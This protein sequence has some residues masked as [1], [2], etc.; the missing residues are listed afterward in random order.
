MS[1][2]LAG[3]FFTTE[4]PGEP[5]NCKLKSFDYHVEVS[6]VKSSQSH[7]KGAHTGQR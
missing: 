6:G 2:A 3:G 4:P 1:P 5:M 7:L